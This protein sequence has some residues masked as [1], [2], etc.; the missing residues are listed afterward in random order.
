MSKDSSL[1][2]FAKV[3]LDLLLKKEEE[4]NKNETQESLEHERKLFDGKTMQQSMNDDILGLIEAIPSGH[5]GFSFNYLLSCFNRLVNF[6]NLTPLTLSDDEFV[7]IS[8]DMNGKPI[9]QNIRNYE[10][11]KTVD[12]GIY[13]LNGEEALKEACGEKIVK[14]TLPVSKE[15][16]VKYIEEMKLLHDSS[17]NLHKALNDYDNCSDFGG[18]TNFRALSLIE[19]LLA[20]LVGEKEDEH[21]YTTI[22]YFTNDLDFGRN[23]EE[24]CFTESDGAPIDIS[25]PEKLYDYIVS[26]V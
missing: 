15:K 25:T 17:E 1:Y 11:F 16:F 8:K 26:N 2:K 21:G 19:D 5:S 10:V 3:E 7:E 24:G 12:S 14:N 6:H 23:Y 13:H 22:S 9:Y 18:F 4:E 20:D